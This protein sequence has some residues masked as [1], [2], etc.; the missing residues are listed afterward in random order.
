MSNSSAVRALTGGHT[1]QTGPILPLTADTGGNEWKPN[2]QQLFVFK[3]CYV[4]VNR[5]FGEGFIKDYTVS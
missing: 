5:K 2:S 1:T 3:D 4:W